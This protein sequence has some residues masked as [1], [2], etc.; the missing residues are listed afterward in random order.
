MTADVVSWPTT[1]LYWHHRNSMVAFYV[2][3]YI[4]SGN[5]CDNPWNS[6]SV[7]WTQTL[8]PPL[9]R[10]SGTIWSLSSL[11][12][13]WLPSLGGSAVC[14][15]QPIRLYSTV[16][17]SMILSVYDSFGGETWVGHH[18]DGA[19]GCFDSLWYKGWVHDWNLL[20]NL[21]FC[22]WRF[23]NMDYNTRLNC[24]ICLLSSALIL[25]AEVPQL[26]SLTE[27]ER[28]NNVTLKCPVSENK[29]FYWYKQSFGHVLQTV[30]SRIL[31]TTDVKDSR[32]NLTREVDRYLLTISNV[33]KEDE[34][35]YFCQTGSTYQQTGVGGTF[36]AVNGKI[37]WTVRVWAHVRDN[38]LHCEVI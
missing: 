36:L 32:F 11:S 5:Q 34:A 37:R 16:K 4:W 35:T 22:V 19:T 20:F 38:D 25:T 28:G 3:F 33:S 18:N 23:I 24:V 1:L 7:L 31:K 17:I 2:F 26:I 14:M 21:L 13:A 10:H 8:P 27:V 15:F 9:H 12:I 6:W 29:Y 30:A